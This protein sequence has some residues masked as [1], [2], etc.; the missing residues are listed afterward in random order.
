[1]E[2]PSESECVAIIPARSGSKGVPHKNSRLMRGASLTERAVRVALSSGLFSDVVISTDDPQLLGQKWPLTVRAMPRPPELAGDTVHASQIV[3]YCLRTDASLENGRYVF[4]LLPTSPL[5]TVE[6]LRQARDLLASGAPSVVAVTMVGK[7]LNNLRF[8]DHQGSLHAPFEF[9]LHE[10]RQT[11][12]PL[13]AVTGSVF[14]AHRDTLLTAE[15][16][17][18]ANARGLAVDGTSGLDVNDWQDWSRAEEFIDSETR[19]RDSG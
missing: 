11:Q 16:F 12:E 9:D 4:M 8:M 15:T 13:W 6:Q 1:V 14:A 3:L 5:R 19:S 18:V 17:H 2:I 7:Q 10:Q